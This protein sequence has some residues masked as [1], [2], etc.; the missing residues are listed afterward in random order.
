[1]A[2]INFRAFLFKQNTVRK[3]EIIPRCKHVYFMRGCM[4][5]SIYAISKK[6]IFCNTYFDTEAFINYVKLNAIIMIS[7]KPK[8][9]Y[10]T[11]SSNF[12]S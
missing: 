12:V 4:E 6:I 3:D 10:A 5:K 2:K 1:M 8:V 11:L 7:H 9:M